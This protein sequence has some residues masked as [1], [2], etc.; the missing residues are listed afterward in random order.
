MLFAWVWLVWVIE[1]L[2]S[3]EESWRLATSRHYK[4]ETGVFFSKGISCCQAPT[5]L[6][7]RCCGDE[8]SADLGLG[9]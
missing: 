5:Y 6:S 4:K 3:N 2:L 7:L 8:E 1:W 9:R